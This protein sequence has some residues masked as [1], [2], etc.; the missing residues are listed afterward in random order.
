MKE[1]IAR[2]EKQNPYL[3]CAVTLNPYFEKRYKKGEDC[4]AILSRFENKEKT[5]LICVLDGVGGW[6]RKIVDPGLFT[7]EMVVHIANLYN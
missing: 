7:K 4:Y 2:A 5:N 3:K 1:E 6:Q